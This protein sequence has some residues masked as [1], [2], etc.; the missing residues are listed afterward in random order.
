MLNLVP[1]IH[2]EE[3]VRVFDEFWAESGADV[4]RAFRHQ[5][6]HSYRKSTLDKAFGNSN[7]HDF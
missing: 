1:V 7:R 2:A 3:L 5:A 6:N 4:L